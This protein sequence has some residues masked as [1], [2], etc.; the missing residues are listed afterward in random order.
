MTR[1]DQK[2]L[3]RNFKL[4]I[5]VII[6]LLGSTAT[7]VYKGTD[8]V[9]SIEYSINDNYKESSTN[10]KSIAELKLLYSDH[11]RRIMSLEHSK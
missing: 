11:E 3:N 7:F 9:K 4:N 10:K 2:L 1:E 8:F 6:T 5:A